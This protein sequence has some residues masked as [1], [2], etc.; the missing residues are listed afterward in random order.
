MSSMPLDRTPTTD[1]YGETTVT[2]TGAERV[3]FMSSLPEHDK[4]CQHVQP[5]TGE[6]VSEELLSMLAEDRRMN[7]RH[8]L[9]VDKV[10]KEYLLEKKRLVN[11]MRS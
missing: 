4:R 9:V 11:V 8:H 1:I 6:Y 2:G 3:H 5:A 10:F 7:V